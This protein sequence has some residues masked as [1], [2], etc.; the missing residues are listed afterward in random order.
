[1]TLVVHDVRLIRTALVL[2]VVPEIVAQLVTGGQGWNWFWSTS[3][4][5]ST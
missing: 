3:S 4:S 5:S 2:L 1:M